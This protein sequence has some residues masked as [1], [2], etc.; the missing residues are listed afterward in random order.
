MNP[1]PKGTLAY[2]MEELRIALR[3]FGAELTKPWLPLLRKLRLL[4]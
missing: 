4:P 1:Y 2:D 3:H